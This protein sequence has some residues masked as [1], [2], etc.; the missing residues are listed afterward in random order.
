MTATVTNPE[1]DKSATGARPGHRGMRAGDCRA[2]P[3]G[4]A[5]A[6]CPIFCSCPP[7]CWNCSSTSS[8]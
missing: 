4:S 1:V 3:T 8:R 2:S 7:S 5:K 6:D